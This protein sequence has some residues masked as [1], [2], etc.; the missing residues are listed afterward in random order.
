M[1]DPI[2]E[3]ADLCKALTRVKESAAIIT[4]DKLRQNPFYPKDINNELVR[5]FEDSDSLDAIAEKDKR[6]L[7][8]LNKM[9]KSLQNS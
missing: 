1:K 3:K 6:K 4:F 7:N 8:Q 2:L 5:I 9:I